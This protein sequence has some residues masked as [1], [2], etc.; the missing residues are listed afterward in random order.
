MSVIN[1]KLNNDQWTSTENVVSGFIS[2]FPCCSGGKESAFI[3]KIFGI[4]MINM[5]ITEDIVSINL[6]T[7]YNW[8]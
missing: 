7:S 6:Q 2:G 1:K 3:S 8:F 5:R 4:K